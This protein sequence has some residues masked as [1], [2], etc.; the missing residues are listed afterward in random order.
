MLTFP[1]LPVLF[2]LNP[3]LPP[4]L[5]PRFFLPHT[6]PALQIICQKETKFL[7]NDFILFYFL[8]E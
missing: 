2:H 6:P 4:L 8:N 3:F 7:I 1:L 5:I